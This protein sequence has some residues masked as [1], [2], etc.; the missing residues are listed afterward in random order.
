MENLE[1]NKEKEVWETPKME[2]LAVE[3]TAHRP[4]VGTDGG[5]ADCSLS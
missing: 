4:G 5:F 3:Q 2:E 1:P